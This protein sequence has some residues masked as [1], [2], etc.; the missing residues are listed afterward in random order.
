MDFKLRGLFWYNWIAVD[1][2]LSI[3]HAAILVVNHRSN[4]KT[5]LDAVN[6]FLHDLLL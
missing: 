1:V 2:T 4:S 5:V 3:G 6:V